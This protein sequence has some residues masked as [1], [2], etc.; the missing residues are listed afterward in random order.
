MNLLKRYTMTLFGIAALFVIS[1]F[2]PDFAIDSVNF[3][4]KSALTM[5]SVLPPILIIV[6]LLDAWIPK[7]VIMQHMG[8]KAGF[9]GYL[10]VLLLG[11]FGAGPLYAAFPITA[12]LVKKGAHIKYIVFFLGVWT[13][14]K[15]PILLYELNFFGHYFT[16]IHI[17][18]GLVF[19][20][21]LSE[22]MEKVLKKPH[23]EDAISQLKK[24][25]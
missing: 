25:A 17:T 15:L 2:K 8:M 5:L 3:S 19:Y 18:V 23:I 14:T 4:M 22:I 20:F 12:L 1:I 10:W 9:R 7:E 21:I 16:I 13:T 6:N 24:M 11:S